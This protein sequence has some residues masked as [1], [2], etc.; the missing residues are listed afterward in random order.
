MLTTIIVVLRYNAV[1]P[2]AGAVGDS[3]V[4]LL[5]ISFVRA[6]LEAVGFT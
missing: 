4:L 6:E 2:A 1:V 5:V 3:S